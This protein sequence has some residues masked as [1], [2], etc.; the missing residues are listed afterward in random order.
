M[1]DTTDLSELIYIAAMIL[2][3]SML[4]LLARVLYAKLSR[5]DV[6]HELSESDNPAVGTSLFGFMSAVVIVLAALIATDNHRASD[7]PV[8]LAWDLG[9]VAIYG[10]VSIFLLRF[11][12]WINDRLILHRFENKK[13][14]VEDRNVGAGAVLCGTYIATGL[15]LAGALSGRVS[16]ALLPEKAERWEVM[17]YELGISLAFFVLGQLVLILYA[18][19]YQRLFKKNPLDAIAEDYEVDGRKH[20]GNAAAGI[21]MGGNMVAVGVVL[22]GGTRGD[23][24]GWQQNLLAFAVVS[25]IGLGMLPL[26][27][28]FVDRVLMG[29]ANLVDE[30]YRDRNTNAAFLESVTLVGVAVVVA[31]MVR[32]TFPAA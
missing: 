24:I 21:A 16:P 14:L 18:Q 13:E 1:N 2:L 11:S 19:V 32:P 29:K 30:I 15:M 22:W 27:R 31:L 8:A 28:V 4:L 5:F 7:T 26:W 17:A 9:E 12:G 6:D 25:G 3:V 10:L 23:F 20:G